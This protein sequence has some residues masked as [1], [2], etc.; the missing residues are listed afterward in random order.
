M[1]AVQAASSVSPWMT[2]IVIKSQCT[3]PV[4]VYLA[5]DPEEPT[6][7]HATEHVVPPQGTQ[8]I[9]S[10]WLH[11]E[12]ATLL[13]RTGV[14]EAKILRLPHKAELQLELVATG[15]KVTTNDQVEIEEHPDPGSVPNIDT[16]P[17][18]MR[19]QSFSD[20]KPRP[21]P[22]V[23]QQR[24]AAAAAAVGGQLDEA[25]AGVGPGAS[26]FGKVTEEE[27]KLDI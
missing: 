25:A 2:Q 6:V 24:W 26:V 18:V 11:E 3:T 13:I 10:G 1:G 9:N 8:A 19:G 27:L 21:F 17:M 20:R 22:R 14:D 23:Q 5:R 12:Y 4:R 16:A 7:Q 15:L